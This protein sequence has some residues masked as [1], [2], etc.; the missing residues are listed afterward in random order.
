METK[1]PNCESTRERLADWL[2]DQLPDAERRTLD[3][4]LAQ[5]PACQQELA[6]FRQLW[7]TMGGIATPEPGE[8]VRPRFYGMLAEF[9]AETSHETWTG[10]LQQLWQQLLN[11]NPALRMA[12]SVLILVVGLVV[13][14]RL[15]N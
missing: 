7:H 8:Q 11:P 4:H 13:G 6:A 1:D 2:S 3:A 14:Y 9:E 5:C 12:Y 15:N 10:K